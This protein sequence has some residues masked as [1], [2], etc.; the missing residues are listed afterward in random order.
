M[1]DVF[2]KID[3]SLEAIQAIIAVLFM[4]RLTMETAVVALVMGV[5]IF[6]LPR[7][8]SSRFWLFVLLSLELTVELAIGNWVNMAANGP[9]EVV[10]RI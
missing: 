7:F 9:A 2:S 5:V 3:D 4:R 8:N 1:L 10:V 6:W